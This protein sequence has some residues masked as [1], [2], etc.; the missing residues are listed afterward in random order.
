MIRDVHL[1]RVDGAE[2]L[3]LDE[4][5]GESGKRFLPII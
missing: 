5:G 4:N 3:Y 2:V 1:I